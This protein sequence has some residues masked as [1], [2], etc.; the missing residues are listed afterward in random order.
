MCEFVSHKRPISAVLVIENYLE[1]EKEFCDVVITASSDET[2]KVR[3]I[4]FT[5]HSSFFNLV[6]IIFSVPRLRHR[7]HHKYF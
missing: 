1:E 4:F 7:L 5:L 2:I 6:T 3:S